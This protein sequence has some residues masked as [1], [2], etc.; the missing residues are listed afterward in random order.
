MTSTS[1]RSHRRLR[2]AGFVRRDGQ[3][4]HFVHRDSRTGQFLAGSRHERSVGRI[5]A[6]E[7][8]WPSGEGLEIGT[9]EG[10]LGELIDLLGRRAA[11]GRL[12]ERVAYGE[13][14]T[15]KALVLGPPA[16]TLACLLADESQAPGI[17][18]VI[19]DAGADPGKVV[20]RV[21]RLLGPRFQ[22]RRHAL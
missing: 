4:G 15:E 19:A 11:R 3:A 17:V 1:D 6:G 20:R 16:R 10:T 12:R 7:I 14:G 8:V 22:V 9:I 21:D 18:A 13:D 2:A 5:G